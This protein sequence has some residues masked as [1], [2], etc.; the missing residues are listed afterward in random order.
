MSAKKSALDT[1]FATDDGEKVVNLA[2][3]KLKKSLRAEGFEV[4]TDEN[5]KLKLVLRLFQ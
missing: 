2:V 1:G 5:G 4:T 3:Y